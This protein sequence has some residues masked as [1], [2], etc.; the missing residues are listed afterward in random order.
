[1]EN[2][3]DVLSLG[4]QQRIGMVL[5][6]SGLSSLST[7]GVPVCALFRHACSTTTRSSLCWINAQTLSVWTWK[8][9]CTRTPSRL[10]SLSLL[11]LN[12]LLYCTFMNSCWSS[13]TDR[14]AGCLA[15][16]STR[17]TNTPTCELHQWR[18]HERNHVRND[19]MISC[20][21]LF[22]IHPSFPVCDRPL[23]GVDFSAIEMRVMI[24]N[25]SESQ[26]SHGVNHHNPHIIAESLPCHVG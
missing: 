24:N 1:M 19:V 21:N 22:E 17:N 6:V 12:A 2:W 7:H 8:R 13:L 9:S 15:R 23:E 11:S 5:P 4:E 14:V 25:L 10:G 18:G 26:V 3:A 20:L 16:W